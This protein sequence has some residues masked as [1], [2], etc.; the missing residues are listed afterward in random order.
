M[1]DA[2]PPNFVSGLELQTFKSL[3][4]A[5]LHLGSKMQGTVRGKCRPGVRRYG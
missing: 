2:S 3:R 1:E 4:V 5:A